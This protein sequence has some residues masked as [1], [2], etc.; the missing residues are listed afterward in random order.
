MPNDKFG[1]PFFHP[2][3][4]NGFFYQMSDNPGNDSP[5]LDLGD[6]GSSGNG[7]F[8]LKPNGP[9][10]W[11]LG[12]NGGFNNAIGGCNMNFAETAKRGYMWKENDLRDL[13][14]K[15]LVKIDGQGGDD[16]LSIGMGTGRHSEDGCCQGFTYMV[17]M[18]QTENPTS[19]R[20]RKE[21]WHVSYHTSP[22]GKFTSP[23]VNFKV[24]GHGWFGYGACKY[25]KP[26]PGGNSPEDDNVVL[27]VWI[28]PDPVADI[29][30][31]SMV[32]R[33]ED[34]K[35]NG[36]GND[37]GR[38][39]GAKD[40]VGVW[41]GARCR[42]K[43]N[44]TSGTF[45]FK[46]VTFREIDPFKGFEE[47]QP[48][49]GGGG[50]TGGGGAGSVQRTIH[51]SV[52]RGQ[53]PQDN[54]GY[55]RTLTEELVE[56]QTDPD[57]LSNFNNKA[58][59]DYSM[60][61][62]SEIGDICDNHS[63]TF[64]TYPSGLV[65]QPYWSNSDNNCVA[66]GIDEIDKGNSNRVTNPDNDPVLK[67]PKIYLIYWGPTWGTGTGGGGTIPEAGD[68]YT[69]D[70]KFG[71]EGNGDGQFQDPHDIAFD[72]TGSNLWVC[73]RVRNDVQKFTST[74]TF[75]SKFGSSGSGNGQLNVPYAMEIDPTFT[76][77]YICDRGNHRVQKLT[78]TGT[79]VSKITSVNGRNL[80][81]PEDICFDPSNGNIFICDTGNDRVIKLDSEHNFLEEWN[82]SEGGG[83][84]FEHPHSMDITSTGHIL[85]SCG[86]QPFTQKFTNDGVFVKRWGSEG[87]GQGQVRM[88]LE[89]GDVDIFQRWHLVNNDVR[90]IINVWDTDGNWI[91]QYGATT[92]GSADGQ[93]AE[94]EHVVCHPITGKPYVV[95]AA[96]ERIQVF[97]VEINSNTDSA[98]SLTD[99]IQNKL[100]N[101][102]KQYFNKISQYGGC[103]VPVWGGAV[104]NTLTPL[105]TTANIKKSE[106][107]TALK[108]TFNKG[109][110]PIAGEDDEVIYFLMI[111][112][113]K[114]LVNDNGTGGFVGYHNT[115][116]FTLTPTTGGGGSTAPPTV[117]TFT[118]PLKLQ[119]HINYDDGLGCTTVGGGGGGGPPGNLVVALENRDKDADKQLSDSSTWDNRKRL[120]HKLYKSGSELKGVV[121]KLVAF[122]LKKVGTPGATPV[123][124]AKIWTGNTVKYTSPTTVDPSTLT[125][126]YPSGD[127]FTT[128]HQF[129]FATNTY[130]LQTGDRIG[131]EYLGTSS[132]NYVKSAYEESSSSGNHIFSQYEGSVWDDKTTRD[133]CIIIW[134]AI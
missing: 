69:Y 98:S 131:I 1:I 29:T 14:L 94:P 26:T 105:P 110:L 24:A 46:N 60:S 41:S 70:F 125:T 38:C 49:T 73:D 119:W 109:L 68:K 91:T 113:G 40:Q 16:G 89:H 134:K 44:S 77:L 53:S 31:W 48:P 19:W 33:I 59:A 27:E 13:E 99:L 4:D 124:T 87:N 11:D 37:G 107:E 72:Q 43:T 55:T 120:A 15:F 2:T 10:D 129:D 6:R 63:P 58:F 65:V 118:A 8:T 5:V 61:P 34:H 47:E 123:I 112:P 90:P 103:G 42:V 66:P 50:G 111:P 84:K 57:P 67:T 52:I 22:E 20:F 75:V 117:T 106:A 130:A 86:D 88:F 133:Q 71:T 104:I 64:S 95:D 126:S 39:N 82:G 45:T 17:T 23:K 122:P 128:W 101:T 83:I 116:R 115:Q 62:V 93:F 32:K 114:N 21:M 35:G 74:G 18:E 3:K 54:A 108:E 12:R 76:Y 78:L 30:N 85:I 36:W 132:S 127:E 51:Y 121:P 100:L 79:F 80:R 7:Q 25:N 81:S 102:N 9:S 96:N 92:R 56:H 97:K 28:N